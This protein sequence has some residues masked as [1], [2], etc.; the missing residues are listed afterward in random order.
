MLH[1][2]HMSK[3]T[4]AVFPQELQLYMEELIQHGPKILICAYHTTSGNLLREVAYAKCGVRGVLPVT[5]TVTLEV[6]HQPSRGYGTSLGGVTVAID[7]LL[8]M[9]RQTHGRYQWYLIYFEDKP[10]ATSHRYYA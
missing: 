2:I 4:W 1:Q 6:K 3:S 10:A 5:T 8:D 7:K 9:Q